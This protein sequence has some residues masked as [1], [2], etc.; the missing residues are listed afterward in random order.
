M[1]LFHMYNLE[2][3]KKSVIRVTKKQAGAIEC[4]RL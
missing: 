4:P 2:S 1:Y 3:R